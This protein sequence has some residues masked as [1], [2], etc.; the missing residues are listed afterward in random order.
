MKSFSVL[1]LVR[2]HILAARISVGLPN[3]DDKRIL[4]LSQLKR[5]R[6]KRVDNKVAMKKPTTNDYEV[7]V[8]LRFQQ[9]D[10]LVNGQPTTQVSD[11]T[12]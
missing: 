4:N 12:R 2:Y 8:A 3:K 10:G 7:N 5:N 6:R 11:R 1:Q 9:G